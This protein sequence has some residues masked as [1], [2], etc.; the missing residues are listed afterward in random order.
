MSC[1]IRIHQRLTTRTQFL[2]VDQLLTFGVPAPRST[3]TWI[4]STQQED[5]KTKVSFFIM[6]CGIVR[7]NQNHEAIVNCQATVSTMTFLAAYITLALGVAIIIRMCIIW[8]PGRYEDATMVKTLC[9][10]DVNDSMV[11]PRTMARLLEVLPTCWQAV[12]S[13]TYMRKSKHLSGFVPGV[14]STRFEDANRVIVDMSKSPHECYASYTGVV[15]FELDGFD[16]IDWILIIGV[17]ITGSMACM[18]YMTGHVLGL[19]SRHAILDQIDVE[20]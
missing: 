18:F 7:S 11:I 1:S 16:V 5:T 12:Y 4:N 9:T 19:Y 2:L 15:K 14:C 6:C 3:H 13:V 10:I 17:V 20:I 8:I